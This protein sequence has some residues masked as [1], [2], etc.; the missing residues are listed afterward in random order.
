[1]ST[2]VVQILNNV[3]SGRG[4]DWEGT[5][6]FRIDTTSHTSIDTT[7]HDPSDCNIARVMALP[8]MIGDD[9]DVFLGGSLVSPSWSSSS[10]PSTHMSSAA[11]LSHGPGSLL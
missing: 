9:W 6:V 10:A 2:T 4:F 8:G 1:M 11:F 7:S 5:G 3:W